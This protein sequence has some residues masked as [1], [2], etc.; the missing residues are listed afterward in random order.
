M[1]ELKFNIN[2]TKYTIGVE[3]REDKRIYFSIPFRLKDIVVPEM[4]D[5]FEGMKWH[6]H[7]TPSEKLWSIPESQPN[8]FRY[9][10]GFGLADPY[11]HYDTPMVPYPLVE[12]RYPHQGS[13]TDFIHTYRQVIIA[14]EMGTGK[15]LATFDALNRAAIT[16]VI[17]VAPKSALYSLMLE[18]DKWGFAGKI[19]FFTHH[20][21]RKYVLEGGEAPR[22][23]ILDEAQRFKSPVAKQTIAATILADAVRVRYGREGIVALLTG[24]A[25]PKSPADLWS[26]ARIACPGFLRESSI[27][28]FNRRMSLIVDTTHPV[29]G[30]TYPKLVTWWDDENKCKHCGQFES[31]AYHNMAYYFKNGPYHTFEKSVDEVAKLP[32]R[33]K[34]L[35]QVTL[36][37]DVLKCLPEK[38]YRV[39]HCPPSQSTLRQAQL[40]ARLYSKGSMCLT[41]LREL[42]DGFQYE[43]IEAGE[44][45]CEICKGSKVMLDSEYIGPADDDF[46]WEHPDVHPEYYKQVEKPCG[47]CDGNG[48]VPKF[49]QVAEQVATPKE[50]VLMDLLDEYSDVGRVVVWAG[51]YG[52]LDRVAAICQRKD[53]QIIQV[54]GRGWRSS[55]GK[56][57]PQE[58]LR[59]FQNGDKSRKIAWIAHP[60]AGG[61][62]VTLTASPVA[63][64]YSNDFNYE[65]RGQSED[66][67]H[68]IGMDVNKGAMIVDIVHLPSD[69][70]VLD[71]LTRKQ[72]LQAIAIGDLHTALN[73]TSPPQRGYGPHAS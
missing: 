21:L 58:M 73:T 1:Q 68:R 29:T 65:N 25:A 3:R 46:D 35:I 4:K 14:A 39:I 30:T 36:K 7:L 44:E 5:S 54:D 17:W 32:A 66:R 13:M 2:G 15:T 42:S 70:Y 34:G 31:D 24:T 71:N 55:I 50:D 41:V 69:Q 12:G 56:I 45:V 72:K 37:R 26:L 53:W 43:D 33:M 64:Y 60:G 23:L 20:A 51:F 38:N 10:W 61:T 28:A 52:A 9:K 49:K 62:G 67:I 22:A 47:G 6:G 27:A 63:V 40:L 59:E 48:T 18:Q 16:D 11:V 57:K 19:R 8:I